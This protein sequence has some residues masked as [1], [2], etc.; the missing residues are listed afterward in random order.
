VPLNSTVVEALAVYR[1]ARGATTPRQ[2]FFRS[3]SGR[4]MSRG[5]VYERVRTQA[6]R[7]GI[8]KVVSPHRLRHTFATHLVQLDTRLVTIRD[9]LGHRC[10][11]STQIYLHVTAKDLAEA[12]DRHP[13]RHLV[14]V[15]DHL[16]PDVKLPLQR[17]PRRAGAG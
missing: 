7:A 6:W 1:R 17:A 5:A 11:T 3:R 9:L 16:L 2:P 8:Q 15:V 4:A 12:M 10:I 14:E 13:I